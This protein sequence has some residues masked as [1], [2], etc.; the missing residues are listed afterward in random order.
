[1]NRD[2]QGKF[3]SKSYA[4]EE[5]VAEFS[6]V[7]IGQQLGLNYDKEM[8]NNSKAYLQNWASQLKEDKSLL[9]GAIK[10]AEISSKCIVEMQTKEGPEIFQQYNQERQISRVQ[11]KENENEV[12]R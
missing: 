12:E 4:R 8:L 7:F 10:D 6:S 2:L 1:M 9:Y 5:L 11:E 3:G